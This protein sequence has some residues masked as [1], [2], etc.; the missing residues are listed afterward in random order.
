MISAIVV[1]FHPDSSTI[2]RLLSSLLGQVAATFAVD[3]TPGSSSIEPTFLEGFGEFVSYIPLGENRG[4]A[5]AQNIGIELSIKCGCSHVL[6]LDQDSAPCP[7]MVSTLLAA[8]EK[9]L[10]NGEKI[11]GMSPQVIDARLGKRPCACLYRWFGA[12]KI[13]RNLSAT[14]PVGTDNFIA[15]GSLIQT[16]TLQAVG[17]MRSDLFIDYVDTEWALRAR[18]AGYKGY[19]VPNAVL[20]HSLGDGTA[21]VL[22]KNMHMHSDL[23][24]YYQLRN[25]VYLMRLKTMG[26][27]WRAYELSRIPYH[28]V[29]Y[30]VLSANR[31]RAWRLLLLAI[32]DGMHGRLG[33]IAESLARRWKG[34]F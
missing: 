12:R 31:V 7:G 8:E 25:E 34:D 29:L 1:L 17:A 32:W 28:F 21:K 26:W 5:E 33:P 16:S 11:S 20:M 24:H 13:Y 6:L 2:Q 30:S 19:C 23:R 15:S 27:Q 10:S 18:T 3:N 9:L 14:E 4:I 22:G